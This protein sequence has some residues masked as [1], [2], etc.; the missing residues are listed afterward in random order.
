MRITEFHGE[1]LTELC[2]RF[3]LKH[4]ESALLAPFI[5]NNLQNLRRDFE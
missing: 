2:Q 4:L 1:D 3:P 5:K